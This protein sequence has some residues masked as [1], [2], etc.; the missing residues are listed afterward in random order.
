EDGA[1]HVQHQQDDGD[2]QAN[3]EQPQHGGV[4]LGQFG[5]DAR[6]DNGGAVLS[7]RA[8]GEVDHIDVQEAN[9]GHKD[10]NAAANGVL[11]AA[12]NGLDDV[13]ADLRHGDEDVDQAA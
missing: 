9:V 12:G 10:A 4:Q 6:G 11:Q 5:H 1:F 8:A 2:G 3:E 7:H 13:L